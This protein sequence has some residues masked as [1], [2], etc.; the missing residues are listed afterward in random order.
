LA[1]VELHADASIAGRRLQQGAA[2]AGSIGQQIEEEAG[3]AKPGRFG[4]IDVPV[5]HVG[6]GH[7]VARSDLFHRRNQPCARRQQWRAKINVIQ[8]LQLARLGREVFNII[9]DGQ[10]AG[11]DFRAD[12]GGHA[13]L[14]PEG[15]GFIDRADKNDFVRVGV[16]C[17]FHLVGGLVGDLAVQRIAERA[18]RQELGRAVALQPAADQQL[19]KAVEPADAAWLP[20]GNQRRMDRSVEDRRAPA[21]L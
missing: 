20:Q 1:L 12:G 14:L 11:S 10:R 19:I 8:K 6:G 3:L 2:P 16:D 7:R 17:R 5:G 4:A 18:A 21:E 13:Q 9:D 15:P